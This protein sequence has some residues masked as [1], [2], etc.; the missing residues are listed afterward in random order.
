VEGADGAGDERDA[1]ARDVLRK[2]G[3]HWDKLRKTDRVGAWQYLQR[4]LMENMS[5]LV[6]HVVSLKDLLAATTNIEEMLAG[7]KSDSG[8]SPAEYLARWLSEA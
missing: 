5:V 8:E 6:P 4:G 1:T 3:K 2:L 7:E